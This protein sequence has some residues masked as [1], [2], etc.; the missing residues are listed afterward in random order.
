[1]FKSQEELESFPN[2]LVSLLEARPDCPG[3]YSVVFD[4]VADAGPAA[5]TVA[6]RRTKRRKLAA[7]GTRRAPQKPH[8]FSIIW[9][10]ASGMVRSPWHAIG[11]NNDLLPL[12]SLV[13]SMYRPPSQ[14]IL[15]DPSIT[16]REFGANS[17]PIWDVRCNGRLFEGCD[18]LHCA[19]GRDRRTVVFQWQNGDDLCII[20]DAFWDTTIKQQEPH[21]LRAIHAKGHVPGV[22]SM[23]TSTSFEHV[24][25]ANR[26]I[27]TPSSKDL[28]PDVP[29]R[30]RLRMVLASTGKPL[31]YSKS[32]QELLIAVYD[33]LEGAL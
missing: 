2:D 5:D 31:I 18:I 4:A 24:R 19:E 32:V 13:Y 6:L 25:A 10:D 17:N 11:T 20:K 16:W 15:R 1:M 9:A 29:M 3:V 33:A 22:V 12:V 21:V 8:R 27:M 7:P 26:R 28:G 30:E 14:H 23:R